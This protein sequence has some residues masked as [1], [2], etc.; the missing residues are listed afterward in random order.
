MVTFIDDISRYV[1]VFF[2]KE[3]FETFDKFKEFKEI[4]E[5]E[6]DKKIQCL[7]TDNGREYTSN[8]F[9]QYP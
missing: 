9:S 1:W 8:K 5:G 4:I 2:M 6:V 3:K 7:Q